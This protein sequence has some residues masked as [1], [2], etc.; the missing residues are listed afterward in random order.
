M[1]ERS[2]SSIWSAQRMTAHIDSP[3][4]PLFE[5]GGKVVFQRAVDILYRHEEGGPER[6]VI[7]VAGEPM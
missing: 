1:T 6:L 2:A 7:F 3:V 4:A 5:F